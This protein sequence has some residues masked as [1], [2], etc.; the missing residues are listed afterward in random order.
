MH[1]R[2]ESMPGAMTP[3]RSAVEHPFATL[4]QWTGTAPF[5][6]RGPRNVGTETSLSVL[7]HDLQ[8]TMG[9]MVT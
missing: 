6:T 8:R 7:A 1:E 4:K 3:R 5:P 9:I 2:V